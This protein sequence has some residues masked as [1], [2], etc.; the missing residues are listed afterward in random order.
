MLEC[1][2]KGPHRREN[3]SVVWERARLSPDPFFFPP[4]K[5]PF[6]LPI[7][8][9]RTIFINKHHVDG[10]NA[11]SIIIVPFILN[12]QPY[13]NRLLSSIFHFFF[14]T[15]RFVTSMHHHLGHVTHVIYFTFIRSNTV[16][17][18]VE[19]AP[20][21]AS[22]YNLSRARQFRPRQ[23]IRRIAYNQF[24]PYGYFRIIFK[25]DRIPIRYINR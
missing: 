4:N 2:C 5:L 25:T 12:F 3:F 7:A 22:F 21:Y 10:A 11:K 15:R 16:L 14:N 19:M 18:Q 9:E 23:A 6:R 13:R 17:R 1:L 20:I 8:Y 24:N